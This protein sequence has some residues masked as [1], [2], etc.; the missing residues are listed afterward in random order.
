MFNS[1]VYADTP[2]KIVEATATYIIIMEGPKFASTEWLHILVNWE[3]TTV[4]LEWIFAF[5]CASLDHRR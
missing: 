4:E 1:K 2:V 3:L 5:I